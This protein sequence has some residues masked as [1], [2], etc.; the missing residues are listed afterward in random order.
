MK[1]GELGKVLSFRTGFAHSGPENWSADKSNNTWFFDKSKAFIGAMG[2]LGVHKLDLIQWLVGQP[3]TEVMAL[4]TTIDKRDSSG[5]LISV[6]DN[7]RCILK[8]R[9]GVIGTLS[10]SWT[11]YGDEENG[12]AIYGQN[13]VM[14]IFEDPDYSIV[15]TKSNGDKTFYQLGKMQT[16]AEQSSSGVIDAFVDSI[17]RQVPPEISGEEGLKTLRVI[18]ACLQSS[19]IRQMVPVE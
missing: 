12:T 5:E 16:N 3:I 6:D 18:E 8:M 11:C 17:V 19:Q 4:V 1:V 2:D 15:I 10:V 13:G 7:A 14:K 9:N